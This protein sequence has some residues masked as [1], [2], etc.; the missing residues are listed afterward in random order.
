MIFVA[1]YGYLV[2]ALSERECAHVCVHVCGG[3]IM[4]ALFFV[5]RHSLIR[6]RKFTGRFRMVCLISPMR[7]DMTVLRIAVSFY[8][9][10]K[11]IGVLSNSVS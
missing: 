8:L 11:D 9:R 2:F 3:D 7:L 6:P 10:K 5:C 1:L 4:R